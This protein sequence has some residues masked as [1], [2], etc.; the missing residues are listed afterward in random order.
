MRAVSAICSGVIMISGDHLISPES[1]QES[2]MSFL[3]GQM[4]N[5]TVSEKYSK[6]EA[7]ELHRGGEKLDLGSEEQASVPGSVSLSWLNRKDSF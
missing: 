3:C 1:G 4:Q 5:N 2:D 6:W 7:R